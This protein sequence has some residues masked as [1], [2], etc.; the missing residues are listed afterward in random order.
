MAQIAMAAVSTAATISAGKAQQQ[1]YNA[2]A[3][4]A[5]IQ[6]RSQ[7]IAYRQQGA[8]VLRNLNETL[9]ATVTM[10]A[11]G[12]VD[13]TSGSARV[14]QEFARAEAYAEYGTAQD[15][16]VLALEGAKT[17]AQIYQMAGK[18]AYQTSIVRGATIM[19]DAIQKSLSLQP[20][21]TG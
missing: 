16:A 14:M 4:E 15:N 20:G 5:K 2:Q 10:A 18:A 19:G 3:A 17:Q 13:P 12:N 11:G 9:A 1:A 7:A 6:G 8:Y 21:A